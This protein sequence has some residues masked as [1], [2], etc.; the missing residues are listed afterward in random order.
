MKCVN[1]LFDGCNK[2]KAIVIPSAVTAIGPYCFRSC[3]SLKTITSLPTTP[4]TWSTDSFYPVNPDVVYVP[5]GSVDAYKSASG[6]SNWSAKIQ[7]IEE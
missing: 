4:P 2:L 7:P 6:W 3:S 1:F 5:S